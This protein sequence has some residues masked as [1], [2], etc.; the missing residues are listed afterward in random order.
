M[1]LCDPL[2]FTFAKFWS[3]VVD[4]SKLVYYLGNCLLPIQAM[5]FVL[6]K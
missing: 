5:D 3:V 6:K 2:W 1:I 4:F